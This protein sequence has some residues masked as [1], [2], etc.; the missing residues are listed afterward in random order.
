MSA[1]TG[2]RIAVT[3]AAT[4]SHE[5]GAMLS[6]LGACVVYVPLI[7]IAHLA[8]AIE[9]LA[10]AFVAEAPY[11]W[12]V[13]TSANG[14]R[15]V[16]E[17]HGFPTASKVAVIGPAVESVMGRPADFRPS[18]PS[19]ETLVAEFPPGVGRV[20]VVQGDLAD[21]TVPNGLANKGWTI[22]RIVAY[23]TRPRILSAEEA[24]RIAECDAVTLYSPS[25]VHVIAA[26]KIA[27]PRI[28]VTIGATTSTACVEYGWSPF[29]SPTATNSAV[30]HR[31]TELL[32]ELPT[33]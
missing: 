5:I 25:A 4:Q 32:T 14:A 18:I 8:D 13:I 28:I 22:E 26:A 16:S 19:A 17:A 15:C 27:I 1:L 20:L 33:S 31:L 2:K 11:D 9:R 29:Q 23:T 30:A 21:T 24:G 10:T 3:R 7:E 12:I 6:D